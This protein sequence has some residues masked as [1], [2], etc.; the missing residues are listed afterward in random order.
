MTG[1]AGV[2][3]DDE[4]GY[5]PLDKEALKVRD[6]FKHIHTHMYTHTHT[7]TQLNNWV[8]PGQFIGAS[9]TA[10]K[11]TPLQLEGGPGPDKVWCGMVLCSLV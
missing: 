10:V 1:I 6:I 3:D 7:H 5:K 4:E 9:A 2:P 8:A 11:A